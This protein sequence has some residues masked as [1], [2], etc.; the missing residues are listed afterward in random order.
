MLDFDKDHS[1][2]F[3]NKIMEMASAAGLKLN[4][5]NRYNENKS[6]PTYLVFTVK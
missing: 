3:N 5:V 6:D 4:H 2:A 1:K